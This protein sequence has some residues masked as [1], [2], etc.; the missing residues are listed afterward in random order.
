VSDLTGLTGYVVGSI[1]KFG[2]A[3]D[4]L[5]LYFEL[6]T[7]DSS[8]VRFLVPFQKMNTLVM[9]MHGALDM[10]LKENAKRPGFDASQYTARIPVVQHRAGLAVGPGD[11]RRV[12]LEVRSRS[13]FD[14]SLVLSREQ[15]AQ[16]GTDLT[17][18]SAEV[19]SAPAPPPKLSS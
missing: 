7:D 18:K 8:R 17:G 11:E 15:A 6:V 13:G 1:G 19:E 14:L 4:G 5:T 3:D 16:I 10:A 12:L 2:V 9:A